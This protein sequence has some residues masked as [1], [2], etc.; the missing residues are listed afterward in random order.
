[1]NY[2]KKGGEK[3]KGRCTWENKKGNSNI[4]C[5]E[6]KTKNKKEIV[7]LGKESGERSEGCRKE[8]EDRRD[9]KKEARKEVLL[10]GEEKKGR[11]EM[12][13]GGKMNKENKGRNEE[14]NR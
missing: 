9:I 11:G 6:G 5:K 12:Q 7:T 2:K 4:K 1:M 3:E 13:R 10:K 14:Q 8:T